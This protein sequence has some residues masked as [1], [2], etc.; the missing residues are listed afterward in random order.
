LVR[1]VFELPFDPPWSD[2]AVMAL[3]TVAISALLGALGAGRMRRMSPLASL[4][5]S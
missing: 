1:F 5:G 3:V 2:F 4:R